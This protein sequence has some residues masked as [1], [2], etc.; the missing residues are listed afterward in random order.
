MSHTQ[1]TTS[2]SDYS[3]GKSGNIL[4]EH[5]SRLEVKESIMSS[6]EGHV[7][8]HEVSTAS[9]MDGHDHHD[10]D[11]TMPGDS[12]NGTDHGGMVHSAHSTM[13]HMMKMYFHTG[14]DEIILFESWTISTVGGLIGSMVI[15]FLMATLYEGLKYFREYLFRRHYSSV[16]FSCINNAGDGPKMMPQPHGSW[17]SQ[18]LGFT[19]ILQTFLH[20]VQVTLSYFLMLIFM[21]YNVWLCLA[22][23]LGAGLGFFIFG[24][25]KAIVVDVTEHCH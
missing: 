21:T 11:H 15:I 20:I 22:V 8:H 5:I 19:H 12:I 9:S 14:V 13:E 1:L 23:V 24:W 25:K 7:H 16:N 10:H 6:H 2:P 18:L 4:V 3:L 17:R